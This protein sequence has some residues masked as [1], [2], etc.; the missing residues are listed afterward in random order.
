MKKSTKTALLLASCLSIL[1]PQG[2]GSFAHASDKDLPSR[3][4]MWR[5]I[6]MQQKQIEELQGL[7]KQ[8]DQKIVATQTQV[9]KTVE[10][11]EK[12]QETV[13]NIEPAAGRARGWWDKTSIGGYG[14]LHYNGGADDEIDLHRFVLNVNHDFTDDIRFHSEVEIEHALAGEGEPG[15]VEI[16]QAYVEFDLTEGDTQRAKAGVFLIPVGMLNETH[17]PATFYGVERNPVE[18]NIIPTTWWEAGGALSGQI[19]TSGFSYDVAIHSGLQTPTAGNNAFRIRNGRQKVAEAE[20]TDPAYTGRVKWT[21]F[22]GVELAVTGQYQTDISQNSGDDEDVE[23]TLIEAHANIQRGGW[24]LRALYAD[25][26]LDGAAPE[27]IG[28]DEQYGWYIEPS[29]RFYVPF[30]YDGEGEAGIFARYNKWDNNAGISNSRTEFE[31]T[32]VGMNYWPHENVV[33]K[34]DMAFVDGPTSATDDEILNLGV[35]WNF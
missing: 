30:G 1:I 20:A 11:I 33:L 32:D 26:N 24:G 25:W 23:A 13:A 22:P 29:Y 10:T 27:A 28:R 12:T 31:Q 16:E 35:G 3:E 21:G 6:Q 19:G 17:E 8:Q 7:T 2:Y 4:E 18:N 14:E 34:A 15:E 9:N 5:I